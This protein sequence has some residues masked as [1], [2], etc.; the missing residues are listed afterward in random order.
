MMQ[1]DAKI[2]ATGAEMVVAYAAIVLQMRKTQ[3]RVI[4]TKMPKKSFPAPRIIHVRE[5]ANF[6]VRLFH[7]WQVTQAEST[8]P[9]DFIR[10]S[11]FLIGITYDDLVADRRRIEWMRIRRSMIM[12][13]ADRYPNL[14][15]VRLGLLFK[16]DHTVILGCLNR[17]YEAPKH[18]AKLTEQQVR[19]IKH[20]CAQ[21]DE[22]QKD[23]AAEYGV[24][25]A[26]I[27][28][29]A[30]GRTWRDVGI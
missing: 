13:T 12:E 21:Y 24:S 6:H 4:A 14:S 27:C 16:R 30:T 28:S 10:A 7:A 26:T 25:R 22:L 1:V 29:I 3:Q 17:S 2:Y 8:A 18:N 19:A 5:D 11:C 23:L 9:I 15:S 20:R